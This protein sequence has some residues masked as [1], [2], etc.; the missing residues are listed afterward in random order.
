M[1]KIFIAAEERSEISK[2]P[3]IWIPSQQVANWSWRLPHTSSFGPD[4]NIEVPDPQVNCTSRLSPNRLPKKNNEFPIVVM[5]CKF[6]KFSKN[7]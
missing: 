4:D 6:S 2:A 7:L 3:L 5:S 1:S